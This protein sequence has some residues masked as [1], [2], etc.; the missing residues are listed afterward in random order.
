MHLKFDKLGNIV[1]LDMPSYNRITEADDDVVVEAKK[2][3]QLEQ[4]KAM[5][6]GLNDD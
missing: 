3:V 6:A 4:L 2:V 5:A 1:G